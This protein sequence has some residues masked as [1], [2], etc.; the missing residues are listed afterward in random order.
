M[1][2]NSLQSSANKAAKE[3]KAG[4][5][6]R[7]K[8]AAMGRVTQLHGQKSPK[9]LNFPTLFDD[10]KFKDNTIRISALLTLIDISNM[11]DEVYISEVLNNLEVSDIVFLVKVAEILDDASMREF[12]NSVEL[13]K[14][15]LNE[16]DLKVILIEILD[17]VRLNLLNFL[18][19]L[20]L[21]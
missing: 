9:T 5:Y 4:Q 13:L 12:L 10:I 16:V 15:F 2:P 19:V 20:P 11:L 18:G 1:K 14:D 7:Q 21:S 6:L 3:D 8:L 17:D